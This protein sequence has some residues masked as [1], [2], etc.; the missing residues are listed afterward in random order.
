MRV[1]DC[2]RA[3][4]S[5]IFATPLNGKAVSPVK[6]SIRNQVEVNLLPP[7]PL[8]PQPLPPGGSPLPNE[9]LPNPGPADVPPAPQPDLPPSQVP[10]SMG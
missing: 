4:G 9:D 1:F 6:G 2:K 8:P 5:T 7:Q 10:P 3:P